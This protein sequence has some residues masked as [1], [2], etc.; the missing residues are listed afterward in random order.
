MSEGATSS[1]DEQ[2]FVRL[3]AQAMTGAPA[4][5][6]ELV[7]AVFDEIAEGP[8]QRHHRWI[9]MFPGRAGA[10]AEIDLRRDVATRVIGKLK[11]DDLRRVR[12]WHA[13]R[14]DHSSFLGWIMQI[15]F[16][17]AVDLA[18]S[19]EC[20][21]QIGRK[22][23][24]TWVTLIPTEPSKL[25]ERSTGDQAVEIID[26]I[27]A[28]TEFSRAPT[29][30]RQAM[31]GYCYSTQGYSWEEI[32]AKVAPSSGAEAFRKQVNRWLDSRRKK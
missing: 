27:A 10:S 14:E 4:A 16:R 2:R 26:R 32:T 5:V 28:A 31:F 20:P 24:L 8:R 1:T 19:K 7:T 25:P 15:A 13:R 21:E 9:R 18:R 3:V 11:D 29:R 6:D 23:T 22:G 30:D 12:A 17:A